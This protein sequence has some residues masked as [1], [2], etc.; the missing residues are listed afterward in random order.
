MDSYELFHLAEESIERVRRIR[1][2]K[3]GILPIREQ[4]RE[5]VSETVVRGADFLVRVVPMFP[6]VLESFF[7]QEILPF[8]KPFFEQ[9]P[10]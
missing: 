6:I 5:I 1:H 9:F 8:L 2:M 10:E 7:F 4:V 3:F